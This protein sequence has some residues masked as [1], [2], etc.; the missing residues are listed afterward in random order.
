MKDYFV[1]LRTFFDDNI[2]SLDFR[3]YSES[4]VL[5]PNWEHAFS[6]T[7]LKSQEAPFYV[8][9]NVEGRLIG[10]EIFNIL[11]TL[12]KKYHNRGHNPYLLKIEED[13]KGLA[14]VVFAD[15]PVEGFCITGLAGLQIGYSQ[16]SRIMQLKIEEPH[17]NLLKTFYDLS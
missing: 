10:L 4:G 16:D 17:R 14:K 2:A 5:I 9:L 6:E 1:M 3:P 13:E 12:P 15:N 11:R 7:T 8:D